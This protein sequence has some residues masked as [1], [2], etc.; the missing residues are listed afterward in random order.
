MSLDQHRD[1]IMATLGTVANAPKVWADIAL[2]VEY[3]DKERIEGK[4]VRARQERYDATV[5]TLVSLHAHL[6]AV[7]ADA[8]HREPLALVTP[9]E[10][11]E[12]WLNDSGALRSL[13]RLLHEIGEMQER[14][15]QA[16]RF[17][18]VR[19]GHPKN[20]AAGVL[21][22]WLGQVYRDATGK[23]P[24]F[25]GSTRTPFH[26]FAQVVADAAGFGDM[27]THVREW[28]GNQRRAM[29]LFAPA[30]LK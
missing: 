27:T 15:V 1:A 28:C 14:F 8:Y 9:R 17:A 5:K 26:R 13:D 23:G 18:A 25:S 11:E 2:T 22:G 10:A 6:E 24:T 30:V 29:R 19:R 3:A 16:R 7:R 12:D 20:Q 4:F 21:V